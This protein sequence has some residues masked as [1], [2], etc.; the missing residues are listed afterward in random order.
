MRLSFRLE[1]S[2]LPPHSNRCQLPTYNYQRRNQHGSHTSDTLTLELMKLLSYSCFDT[3]RKQKP[4][5]HHHHHPMTLF[6]RPYLPSHDYTE[7]KL[8][9]NDSKK[10]SETQKKKKK[11]GNGH[12]TPF[13]PPKPKQDNV[14]LILPPSF[15]RGSAPSCRIPIQSTVSSCLQSVHR[16]RCPLFIKHSHAAEGRSQARPEN[17]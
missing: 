11:V 1:I 6:H 5:H 12:P 17:H 8:E 7:E 4:F 15:F 2:L 16:L 14:R 10:D 3:F 13:P 9:K